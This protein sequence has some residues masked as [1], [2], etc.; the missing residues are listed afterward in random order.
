MGNCPACLH[1]FRSTYNRR[2]KRRKRTEKKT[3]F[4]FVTMDAEKWGR[5]KHEHQ[6]FFIHV[7]GDQDCHVTK[8]LF[9][10]MKP[11]GIF[12][13]TLAERE[14]ERERER[15]RAEERMDA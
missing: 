11:L 13:R 3:D 2:R 1:K 15:E 6:V 5:R 9:P 7:R 12:M 4:L 10:S 8:T 14:E